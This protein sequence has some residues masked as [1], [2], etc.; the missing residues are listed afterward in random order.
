MTAQ[1]ITWKGYIGLMFLVNTLSAKLSTMLT[2]QEGQDFLEYIV[3]VGFALLVVAAIAALYGA[4][5]G[6]FED[7]AA[8]VRGISF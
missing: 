7:A 3:I 1:T 2:R 6:L 8:A 4:I 5:N